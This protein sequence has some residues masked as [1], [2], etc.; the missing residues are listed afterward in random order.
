MTETRLSTQSDVVET[1]ES[2][3]SGFDVKT[4]P[5]QSRPRSG[6]IAT[7]YKSNLGSNITFKIDFN[8][9]HTSYEEVQAS[10]TL[11]H[12]TLHFFCSYRPPLNRR[13][14]LTDSMLTKQL[15]DLLDYINNLPGLVCLVG[16]MNI[17][18]DNAQQ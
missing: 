2:I 3:P 14:N 8:F 1:D 12:N 9:T 18:L 6:G 15:P 7:I 13:N 10:V 5:R 17:Q 4:F 16:D 11:Q